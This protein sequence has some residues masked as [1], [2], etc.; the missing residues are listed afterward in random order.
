MAQTR[1][2]VIS[3]A[4]SVSWLR[5]SQP[6]ALAPACQA[7]KGGHRRGGVV[8]W[9]PDGQGHTSPRL[10]PWLE[11]RSPVATPA[12]PGGW[13]PVLGRWVAAGDGFGEELGALPF[14][15]VILLSPPSRPDSFMG[16]KCLESVS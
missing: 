2:K 5:W 3:Q 6:E 14:L 10:G 12:G 16:V 13:E 9:G 7:Q 15:G 8:T 4:L 11:P 1:G